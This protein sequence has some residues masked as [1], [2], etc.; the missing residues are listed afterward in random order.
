MTWL[1]KVGVSLL[2]G[3]V[4]A[5]AIAEAYGM[6]R[7]KG[8]GFVPFT[9]I[10][11][12]SYGTPYRYLNNY[13]TKYT[14]G[15]SWY[16]TWGDDGNTYVMCNDCTVPQTAPPLQNFMLN[17]LSGYAANSSTTITMVPG[18][19][20]LTPWGRNSDPASDGNLSFKS[21]GLLCFTPSGAPHGYLY[22]VTR[23]IANAT[24][25]FSSMQL[26]KT[27]NYGASWTPVPPGT[28]QPYNSAGPPVEPMVPNQ[29]LPADFVQYG[30]CYSGT[31]V[32]N[33]A[34]YIYVAVEESI[35]TS[36][37]RARRW[38]ARVPVGAIDNLNIADWQYY[39]GPVGA[40][41]GGT[42]SAYWG[43]SLT[44]AT[45]VFDPAPLAA[46]VGTCCGEIRYLPRYQSYVYFGSGDQ[47]TGVY[48][49]NA[50]QAP[51]PWGP[52][53]LIPGGQYTSGL[54]WGMIIAS[55]IGNG[56]QTFMMM[57][58]GDPG[59]SGDPSSSGNLYSPNFLPVTLSP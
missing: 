43:S 11:S 42:N 59:T 21:A 20:L 8:G 54:V 18:N 28:N 29:P 52:W 15:D 31:S 40:A 1:L 5:A 44:G 55:S 24:W 12:V 23:R 36:L 7:G 50:F 22:L 53:T 46:T 49:L 6:L 51:H 2:V 45:V 25:V 19:A 16:S 48:T 38:L 3:A 14:Q 34:N 4:L 9:S 47:S 56:G 37:H 17:T 57:P 30:Q 10:T 27:T 26:I 33:S 32:D 58:S 13:P 35:T 39:T 41:D